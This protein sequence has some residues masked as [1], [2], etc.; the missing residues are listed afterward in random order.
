MVCSNDQPSS[1]RVLQ[2][3]QD[4]YYSMKVKAH[5]IASKKCGNVKEG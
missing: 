2:P 1:E 4:I 3:Y 5:K